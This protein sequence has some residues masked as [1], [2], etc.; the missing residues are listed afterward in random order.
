M[1]LSLGQVFM[2]PPYKLLGWQVFSNQPF[3]YYPIPELAPYF[4]RECRARF[5]NASLVAS[6]VDSCVFLN[7]SCV[8]LSA[9]LPAAFLERN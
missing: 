9:A 1:P 3:F 5:E 4:D 2:I 8:L 6:V 7:V